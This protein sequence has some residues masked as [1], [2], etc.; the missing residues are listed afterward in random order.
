LHS[1]RIASIGPGTASELARYHLRADIF[2]PEFRAEALAG[3]LAANA[4]GKHFLLARASRGREVLAETL[5]GA[6]AQVEQVV[7]YRSTNVDQPDAEIARRLKCGEVHWVTVTS[8][9]IARSLVVQ[10]GKS[11]HKTQLASISPITSATLR[12]SGFEPTVEARH[13][14]MAGLV[15]AVRK[16]LAQNTAKS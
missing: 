10:Y 3:E 2:P 4:Q 13:Y 5:R 6:G 9:A 8:S 1:V 14:T 12:E 15:A 11:L 16:I 7:V